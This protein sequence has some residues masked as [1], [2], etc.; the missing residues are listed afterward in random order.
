MVFCCAASCEN[1]C[2]QKSK[3]LAE[4]DADVC[5]RQVIKASKVCATGGSLPCMMRYVPSEE[6]KVAAAAYDAEQ[7]E[8]VDESAVVATVSD[9]T[10]KP[11]YTKVADWFIN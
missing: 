10:E 8:V 11:W 3:T 2:G 5:S 9:E 4:G 7:N 6:S 1:G